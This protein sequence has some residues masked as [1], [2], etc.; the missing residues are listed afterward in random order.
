MLLSPSIRVW[1]S[2]LAWEFAVY[3]PLPA[4]LPWRRKSS[5]PA[6]MRVGASRPPRDRGHRTRDAVRVRSLW[7]LV[8]VGSSGR[9]P[10]GVKTTSSGGKGGVGMMGNSRVQG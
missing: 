9:L 6:L 7:G 10:G 5:D 4:G 1:Y 2:G 8:G 3:L